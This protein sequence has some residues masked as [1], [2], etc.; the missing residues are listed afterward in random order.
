[1]SNNMLQIVPP[2]IRLARSLTRLVLRNNPLS[3]SPACALEPDTAGLFA[4]LSALLEAVTSGNGCFAGHMMK[5]VP[6]Q[7]L[8]SEGI[9]HLDVSC[10]GITQ[11][12][13]NMCRLH[14][15]T[16]LDLTDNLLSDVPVE[17]GLC[18]SL[19]TLKIDG[20]R[21]RDFG[22]NICS[23][24]MLQ[25][26]TA[27]RNQLSTLPCDLANMVGLIFLDLRFNPDLSPVSSVMLNESVGRLMGYLREVQ[28][29][30]I[31][32]AV[33]LSRRGI[34]S[35]PIEVLVGCDVI[36]KLSL[37]YN[38][39]ASMPPSLGQMM[40]LRSL[41][42]SYNVLEALPEEI[43]RLTALTELRADSNGITGLPD[44]FKHLSC[45]EEISLERN[46]FEAFP[47]AFMA[48]WTSLRLLTLDTEHETTLPDG[49]V[50]TSTELMPLEVL[51]KGVRQC[52]E[53]RQ[54]L[55]AC[56]VTGKLDLSVLGLWFLPASVL[57][58]GMLT[59]LNFTG[60]SLLML[61]DSLTSLASL[62]ALSL[63]DNKL[64]ILPASIAQLTNL[65]ELS[66][67]DNMLKSIAPEVG[68]LSRLKDLNVT[69]N[70]RLTCPPPEIYSLGT[71]TALSFLRRIKR[72]NTHGQVE[73]AG[74][75]LEVISMPWADLAPTL[76]AL[77][78]S[79]N[80]LRSLPDEIG[81]LTSLTAVWVD[82]NQLSGCAPPPPLLSPWFAPWCSLPEAIVII[83]IIIIPEAS[84]LTSLVRMHTAR[85]C[86][87]FLSP[88]VITASDSTL[89]R[90]QAALRD[91]EAHNPQVA[92]PRQ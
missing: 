41:D 51:S 46:P 35:F 14:T 73:L 82:N 74:L 48:G 56:R 7:V 49:A 72:G 5:E 79:R 43:G 76:K 13:R 26:V 17:L 53:Y 28:M 19:H 67:M 50:H 42:V 70:E 62:T 45:L 18:T 16:V 80:L 8:A 15:L 23:M 55:R 89:P 68:F 33:N 71:P 77:V 40:A 29:G 66:L 59:S 2:E 85:A 47:C 86:M 92:R 12:P 54:R 61:P 9:T 44:A 6:E 83:I 87:P 36:T 34:T 38:E 37:A 63:N 3:Q 27:S 64:S 69:N 91:R 90:T 20:N 25:V 39:I 30:M 24:S 65:T 57:K 81:I 10:N 88:R 52:L 22:A 75:Q 58:M 78:L 21:F 1:M 32:G 11:L 84:T 31:Y 60:N 4:Y